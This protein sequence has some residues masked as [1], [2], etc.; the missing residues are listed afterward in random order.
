ME[1]F[2][3]KHIRIHPADN[4]LIAAIALHADERFLLEENEIMIKERIPLGHKIA[5]KSI[6]CGEKIIKYGLS[7]G[8]ATKDIFPGELVHVHNIKSDYL[9]TY[10]L[11]EG[12]TYVK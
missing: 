7:I 3:Q 9:Q 5:F 10:T 11:E 1:D 12:H 2:K 8:S 6:K 4:V